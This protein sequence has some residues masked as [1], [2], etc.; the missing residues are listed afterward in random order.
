MTKTIDAINSLL[1]GVFYDI[2][3]LEENF[4]KKT[5]FKDISIKELRTIDAIGLNK[6]RI[7][8]YIAKKLDI[9]VGTLTVSINNLEKKE[10]VKRKRS[11]KDKRIVTINLTEKGEALFKTH[12]K[13]KEKIMKQVILSLSQQEKEIFNGALNRFK[14]I[15]DKEI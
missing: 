5:K 8:S 7:M 12:K 15:L 3:K 13:F 2:I 4:L 14:L 9:T 6:N 11:E 1:S 10:Y